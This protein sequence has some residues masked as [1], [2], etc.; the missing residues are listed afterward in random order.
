MKQKIDIEETDSNGYYHGY[1]EWYDYDELLYRG[2]YKH[3]VEIG[4]SELNVN[5]NKQTSQQTLFHIT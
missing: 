5:I 1:Q 3:G 2:N 4:Y